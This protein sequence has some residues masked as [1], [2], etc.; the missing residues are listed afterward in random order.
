LD[1][2]WIAHGG[3]VYQITGVCRSRAYDAY[4]TPF[5]DVAL[6]LRPLSASERESI[7]EDRLRVVRARKGEPLSGLVD[8]TKARWSA[9]QT[10][11]ANALDSDVSLREGQPIKVPIARSYAGPEDPAPSS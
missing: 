3:L 4:Q 11:V 5:I 1:V 2:S 6:S 9:E 8:R 7:T 10:A